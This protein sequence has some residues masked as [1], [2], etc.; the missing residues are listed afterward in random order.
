MKIAI[1][2]GS[3]MGNTKSAADSILSCM[4]KSFDQKDITLSQIRDINVDDLKNYD[5]I[6]FGCSTWGIGELQDDWNDPVE[7]IKNIDLSAKKVALFG[8]GDQETYSDS[9]V[10]ALGTIYSALQNTGAVLV[11][12]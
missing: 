5:L 10:D 3:T 2:Y 1:V 4:E 12:K 8:T 6:L 7:Q 9:F 11:G